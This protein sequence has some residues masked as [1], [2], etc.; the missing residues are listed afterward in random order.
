MPAPIQLSRREREV[1]GL[2]AEGLSNRE[3]AER[4]FISERTAEGHVEQILNKLGFGKRSQIAAWIA[5]GQD[6]PA[7]PVAPARAIGNVPRAL[8]SLV[9]R[10]VEIDA[11]A[12][13]LGAARLITVTGPGGIGKTRV[14]L[15]AAAH[16][17]SA[18]RDGAWFIELDSVADG[19]AV[20]AAVV[21]TLKMP[22]AVG[23]AVG[24]QTAAYFAGRQ[25]LLLLD[26]CEHVIDAC[27]DLVHVILSR[28]EHVRVLATSRERLGLAGERVI[29]IEPLAPRSDAVELFA[30]RT[31]ELGSSGWT[32]AEKAVATAICERLDGMPLAIEL[33]A[34]LTPALSL[35]GIA[36]RLDDR[37]RVLKSAAHAPVPRHQ[38][39]ETAVDWSYQLLA[40]E[41][42][43][44]F[45]RLSIFRGGFDL[46]AASVVLQS[47]A[48]EVVSGLVRKSM[49][50]PRD[51]PSGERR[52]HMLETLRE[53]ARGRLDESGE[54]AVIRDRHAQYFVD[55]S[56][57][58]FARMR[59]A[60]GDLW[61]RRLDLE[62]GN[63]S[64]A[65]D[66]LLATADERF[67]PMVAA[68]G[69]Y[70]IRGRIQDG[71][72]WTEAAMR[73]PYPATKTNLH[74][75]EAWAWLT[76]QSS[77]SGPAFEAMDLMLETALAK[78]DDAMAGRA[79]NMIATFRNDSRL[80]VEPDLWTRAE[81]H[82]RRSGED[83]SLAL[84]LNDI[85]W[86][87][88]IKGDAAAGLPR[89]AEGLELA[90]RVGDRWLI[91]LI[92]DSV[93]WAYTELG[94]V[95][96][97]VEA[98][99]EG[100]SMTVAAADRFALP[101]YLEGFARV[102]RVQGDPA[103]AIALLGAATAVRG[104][105]GARPLES[106]SDYMR[107]EVELIRDAIG[108]AE[109]DACWRSGM[110]MSAEE[111]VEFALVR[112]KSGAAPAPD[113]PP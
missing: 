103:K 97:A 64:A 16:V 4:L 83:W 110:A 82:L 79:L 65:L 76:W 50:V 77:M 3:I 90:R 21:H 18:F 73:L 66:F 20:P 86:V 98:W 23:T 2:V 89:I 75:L 55:L 49:L 53:F 43:S 58:A 9:G 80:P 68:L 62:R 107:T 59:T 47:D 15:E 78:G 34:A 56:Q 87:A 72:R 102:A 46:D 112:V 91:A 51:E 35:A 88:T 57:K 41:E 63:V 99:A 100:I 19:A 105:I 95:D 67:I 8:S 81:E 93:A 1:A 14:A 17:E 74:L 84:L 32:D 36:A 10:G 42:A 13:A 69:R 92:L 5:G 60:D 26:N 101:A 12:G 106:W 94:D 113:S 25:A 109:F 28:A 48:L 71:Y 30:Q 38:A 24:E 44:T 104:G 22:Q 40:S 108:E 7:R 11:I 111:A 29:A 45:R 27:R 31:G 37:F 70:W 96:K 33:A 6:G 61:V 39:L 85:G 52:Y 54:F